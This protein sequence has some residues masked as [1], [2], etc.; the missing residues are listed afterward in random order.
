M[1]DVVRVGSLMQWGSPFLVLNKRGS[2][3]KEQ[4]VAYRYIRRSSSQM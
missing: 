3:M 4:K 1:I 2:A